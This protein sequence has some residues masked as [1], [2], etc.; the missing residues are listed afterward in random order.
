LR[1]GACGYLV[2]SDAASELL[3]AVKAILEGKRFI[4]A[5]LSLQGLVTSD[6]EAS[7]TAHAAWPAGPAQTRSTA[8][9]VMSNK[10]KGRGARR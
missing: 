8:F 4:S 5:S 10:G 2:K 9:F 7:E 6:T 1:T 3:T